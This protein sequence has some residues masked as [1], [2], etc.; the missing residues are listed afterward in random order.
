MKFSEF[1]L[2]ESTGKWDTPYPNDVY[3]KINKESLLAVKAVATRKDVADAFDKY[4]AEEVPYDVKFL[5]DTV[6]VYGTY[7]EGNIVYAYLQYVI[8]YDVDETFSNETDGEFEVGD[9]VY[10]SGYAIVNMN[11]GKFLAAGQEEGQGGEESKEKV[12]KQ[13]SSEKL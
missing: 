11:S 5:R 3:K 2:T 8:Q 13:I 12:I 10:M 7:K 4:F 6:S 9:I 1:L